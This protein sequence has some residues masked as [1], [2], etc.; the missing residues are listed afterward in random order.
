MPPPCEL[1]KHEPTH[2]VFIRALRAEGLSP[3][4]CDS[5]FF[6]HN[7]KYKL[8]VRAHGGIRY[9]HEIFNV[10]PARPPCEQEIYD[11]AHLL[12]LHVELT[13]RANPAPPS[14]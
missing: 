8:M 1:H 13:M 3:V 12:R 11:G 10:T 5:G 6:D 9:Y 14:A 4:D 2:D 7:R